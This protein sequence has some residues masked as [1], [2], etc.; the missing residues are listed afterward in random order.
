MKRFHVSFF[1]GRTRRNFTC[2][3]DE[4]GKCGT[5][6]VR[7]CCY[8][9]ELPIS[10]LSGIRPNET[11]AERIAQ[12]IFGKERNLIQLDEVETFRGW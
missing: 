1:D 7:F 10:C 3:G 4:Q 2:Y 9:G 12:N 6:G 8:T 11:F 5:C